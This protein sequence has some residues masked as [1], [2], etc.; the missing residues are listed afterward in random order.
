MIPV[1]TAIC[2]DSKLSLQDR[3]KPIDQELPCKTCKFAG[4][5]WG[6]GRVEC[7]V[8]GTKKIIYAPLDCQWRE[9]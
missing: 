7:N 4:K 9:T 6:D 8:G 2:T 1:K 5:I 3:N